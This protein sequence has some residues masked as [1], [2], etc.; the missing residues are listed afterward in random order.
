MRRAV[1]LMRMG[2]PG[3]VMAE[4][5]ADLVNEEVPDTLIDAYRA[6]K[7]T[8]AG[9]NARD[10][11][12]AARA[13]RDARRPVIHAGQGGC[14]TPRRRLIC[15]SSPSCSSSGHDHD[16]S[17]ERVPRGSSAGARDRRPPPSPG[18][19]CTTPRGRR[20]LRHRMQLTRHGWRPAS[21]RQDAHPRHQRRARS[22]QELRVQP[23]A[24]GRR[25]PLCSASSSRR[26]RARGPPGR[27]GG[28]TR[29][30]RARA[31]GGLAEWAPILGSSE[32]HEPVSS[33]GRVHA[34]GRPATP[35]SRT[36]RELR[37]DQLLPFYR[38]VRCAATWAGASTRSVSLGLIIGAKLAAPTSSCVNFMGDAASA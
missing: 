21:Y 20:G 11:E 2:R 31:G 18:T 8:S 1:S 27:R 38:A 3:P 5:P 23:P 37:R 17:Q 34:H 25:A 30:A 13:L 32:V 6:V 9:A 4:I 12:S 15:A 36:I 16:G 33:D 29:R 14:C 35:S 24:A 22:Q 19:R 10:V 7:V 28:R 26:S